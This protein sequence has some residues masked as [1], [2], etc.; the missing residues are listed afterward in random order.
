MLDN[1][2]PV[3]EDGEQRV[4]RQE[5]VPVVGNA[6][7]HQRHL[8]AKG[9]EAGL[10]IVIVAILLDRVCKRRGASDGG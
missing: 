10:A 4:M 3:P 1:H 6:L 9:F 7:H 2:V 5:N 8:L